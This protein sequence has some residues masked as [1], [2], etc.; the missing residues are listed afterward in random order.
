MFI[1]KETQKVHYLLLS[2]ETTKHA[3]QKQ[4]SQGNACAFHFRGKNRQRLLK[5]N[6]RK[7]SISVINVCMLVVKS[8]T[9]KGNHSGLMC[10][11]EMSVA[12]EPHLRRR[13][14]TYANGPD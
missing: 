4:K 2:M 1:N 10:P 11:T 8:F 3:Y 13:K 14:L 9:Q 5:E 6:K 12:K 7:T